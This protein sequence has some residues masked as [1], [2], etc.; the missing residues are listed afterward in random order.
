L[1]QLRPRVDKI[2]W[3]IASFGVFFIFLGVG[4]SFYSFPTSSSWSSVFLGI[5]ILFSITVI[6][7]QLHRQNQT[8]QNQNTKGKIGKMNRVSAFIILSVISILPMLSFLLTDFRLHGNYY[9]W[10]LTGQTR[11]GIHLERNLFSV[12]GVNFLGMT[13]LPLTYVLLVIVS[14]VIFCTSIAFLIQSFYR[15]REK[16]L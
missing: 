14:F 7:Y 10:L 2:G 11:I 9:L 4:Y 3:I 13:E 5:G 1:S 16:H 12:V 6:L 15:S 8:E